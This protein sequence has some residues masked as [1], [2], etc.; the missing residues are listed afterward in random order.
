MH[1]ITQ[2]AQF[3]K[4]SLRR[5]RDVDKMNHAAKLNGQTFWFDVFYRICSSW[6]LW[7]LLKLGKLW[8]TFYLKISLCIIYSFFLLKIFVWRS[9]LFHCCLEHRCIVCTQ[10]PWNLLWHLG[11]PVDNLFSWYNTVPPSFVYA[12]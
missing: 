4:R 12:K 7:K 8:K 9:F 3:F 11:I 1:S 10:E 5:L 6:N 2:F